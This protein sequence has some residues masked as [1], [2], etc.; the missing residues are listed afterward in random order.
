ML[1]VDRGVESVCKK[2]NRTRVLDED[3]E[4]R[5]CEKD[6]ERVHDEEGGL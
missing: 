4:I 2:R 3:G 6:K 5:G 1:Y